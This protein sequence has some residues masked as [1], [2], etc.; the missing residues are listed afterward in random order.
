MNY[1]TLAALKPTIGLKSSSQDDDLLETFLQWATAQIDAHKERHYD[2]RLETRL[3]DFPSHGTSLLGMFEPRLLPAQ[4]QPVLRLD[5][6]LLEIVSLEN[7]DGFVITDYVLEPANISPKTRIKL[8]NGETWATADSGRTEQVISVTGIWGSHDRYSSAW[9]TSGYTV[10]NNPLASDGTSITVTGISGFEA[11]QLI[12]LEDEFMLVT[13]V[14]T[15]AGPPATYSLT[16]QRAYNGT[17]AVAHAKETA[18]SIWQVQGNISQACAR[19]V[20]WRYTQKDVDTFDK[21]YSGE[22][23]M[24]SVP[25]AIP[26]DVLALLGAKKA[27]L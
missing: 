9:L 17:A 22:T 3:F 6:D 4:L 25:T 23:G 5:E 20:K 1:V 15:Q 14:N 11:G 7:G 24:V 12:R 10:Q 2:P 19:L 8:I 27:T 13:A 21:T 26:T 16:V 18:I